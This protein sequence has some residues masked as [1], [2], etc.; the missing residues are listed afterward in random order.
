LWK[1]RGESKKK[2]KNEAGIEMV[3]TKSSRGNPKGGIGGGGGVIGY[4]QLGR[5]GLKG[6]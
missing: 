4:L 2:M 1:T 3:T 5:K 6:I